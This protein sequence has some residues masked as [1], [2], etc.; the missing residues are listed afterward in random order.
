MNENNYLR[1]EKNDFKINNNFTT[2]TFKKYDTGKWQ[3]T[4]QK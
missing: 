4:T 2:W 3:K 1:S